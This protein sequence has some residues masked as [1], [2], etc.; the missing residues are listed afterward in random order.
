MY[1]PSEA[2]GLQWGDVDLA[3]RR[4]HVRR[5]RYLYVNDDPKTVSARRT[6]DLFDATIDVL[7]AVL[8]LDD[9]VMRQAGLVEEE[10][11]AVAPFDG[12]RQEIEDGGVRGQWSDAFSGAISR[13]SAL[14]APIEPK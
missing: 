6:V 3:E 10:E 11:I 4:L 13:A 9:G 8:P 2:A 1:R 5:S 12:A 14:T 7:R